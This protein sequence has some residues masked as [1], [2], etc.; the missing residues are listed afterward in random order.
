[1]PDGSIDYVDDRT[2]LYRYDLGTRRHSRILLGTFFAASWAPDGIRAAVNVGVSDR[3]EVVDLRNRSVSLRFRGAS[4]AWSYDSRLLAY[5]VGAGITVRHLAGGAARHM[6]APR[7]PELLAW[8]PDEKWLAYIATDG[9][10]PAW[11]YVMREATGRSY[12]LLRASSFDWRPCP[13][14]RALS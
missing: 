10:T 9:V 2:G 1:M 14:G 11:L 5:G 6:A 13:P 7:W 8:S 4:H 12:R 3:Y